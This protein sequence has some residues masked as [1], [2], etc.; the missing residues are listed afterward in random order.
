[1]DLL[2]LHFIIFLPNKSDIP[3]NI[4]HIFVFYYS[5]ELCMLNTVGN[6]LLQKR[7]L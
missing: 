7:N 2:A 1:M 4:N 6:I 5:Y 3:L